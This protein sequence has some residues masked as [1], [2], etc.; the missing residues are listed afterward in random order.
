MTFRK[1]QIVQQL[2]SFLFCDQDWLSRYGYLPPPDPR[3][4][5]L[6]TREGI[7]KAVRIMQRFGGVNE[8]GVLGNILSARI[9]FTFRHFS[10][11]SWRLLKLVVWPEGDNG[12]KPPLI[13]VF[14]SKIL[15]VSV[16]LA[17][18]ETLKL[19]STPRCSLPDI[20]GSE[21]MLKRRRRRKRYALTGL[22]WHKTE[23]TWRCVSCH[24]PLW[25]YKPLPVW[26]IHGFFKS[27]TTIDLFWLQT[28]G[29]RERA[30]TT[31]QINPY[32]L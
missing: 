27:S 16:L 2:I 10:A 24:D 22:K 5:R 20:V 31:L 6:Q 32:F 23:L 28:F 17:D 18:S 13:S 9:I 11:S 8:T 19:M 12:T 4:S 15:Y 29:Q 21:D 1:P 7:E 25:L 26:F 3:T 14:V 30:R